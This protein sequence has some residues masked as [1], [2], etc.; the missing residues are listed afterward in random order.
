MAHDVEQYLRHVSP[1]PALEYTSF[2]DFLIPNCKRRYTMIDHVET[3]RVDNWL[4]S[5]VFLGFILIKC[6]CQMNRFILLIK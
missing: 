2:G 5:T 4:A 1:I 3:L 6:T